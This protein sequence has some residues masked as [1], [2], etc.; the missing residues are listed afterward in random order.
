MA[1]AVQGFAGKYR[2]RPSGED[3]FPCKPRL[4]GVA[5]PGPGNEL[6]LPEANGS[7]GLYVGPSLARE[8]T[9]VAIR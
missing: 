6:P 1:R 8:V 5:L 9:N 2:S 7:S 4:A 3:D